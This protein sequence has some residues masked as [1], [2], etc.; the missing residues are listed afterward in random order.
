M[1]RSRN[2]LLAAFILLL[3]SPSFAQNSPQAA[4]PDPA[5]P[6]IPNSPTG[7]QSQ[8]EEIVRMKNKKE[9]KRREQLISELRIPDPDAWFASAFGDDDGG[10]LAATYKNSWEGFEDRFTNMMTDFAQQGRTNIS[11]KEISLPA[12]PVAEGQNQPAATDAK[13]VTIFYSAA[14][15]QG[16][17]SGWP[18]P[19]VYTYVQGAFRLVNWQ[20]LYVLPYVKPTRMRIGGNV[21]LAKLVQKVNPVYPAEA[22]KNKVSGSVVLHV[23]EGMDGHI[24]QVE[25]VSGPPEL[26]DAAI[27]AVRQWRYSPTLLNGDPVEV[28]TKVEIVFSLH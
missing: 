3:A 1:H 25:V 5:A 6:A 18:F 21:A 24:L 28:D 8:L 7:L 14:A 10:K 20:T 17:E 27:E 12:K 16:S 4:P 26:I 9:L 2:L 19:G 23:V 15:A 22:R 13:P 11:V